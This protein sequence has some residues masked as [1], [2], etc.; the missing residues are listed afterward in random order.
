RI[1]SPEDAED[2]LQDVYLQAMKHINALDAID[3]L[4]G[5]LF[6]IARNKIID[7]YRSKKTVISMDADDE[8]GRSLHELLNL[9]TDETLDEDTRDFVMQ[10]IQ[11][12]IDEL[13]QAQKSVFIAQVIEGKT[14][15]QISE[16]SGESINTLLARKRYAVQFLQKRLKFLAEIIYNQ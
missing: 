4:S 13:P 7:R 1:A 5:W 6:R 12:G 3:N 2:I 10:A 14:F 8:N 16:E 9:E 11:E 15:R